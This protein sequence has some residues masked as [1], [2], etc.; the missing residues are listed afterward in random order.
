MVHRPLSISCEPEAEAL[1]AAVWHAIWPVERCGGQMR[2]KCQ[3]VAVEAWKE[4][5]VC[6]GAAVDS[7][8]HPMSGKGV[9]RR[10]LGHSAGLQRGA[11]F[12][13]LRQPPTGCGKLIS[14]CGAAF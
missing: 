14:P 5:V 8:L 7:L 1:S 9:G 2:P 6:C 12:F 3:A 4:S 11:C 13:F 10:R